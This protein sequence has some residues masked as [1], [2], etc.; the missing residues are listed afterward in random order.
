M[1]YQRPDF[2]PMFVIEDHY[3]GEHSITELGLR[4]EGYE[5]VLGGSYLGR[6]FGNYAIWSLSSPNVIAQ[7]YS[8]IKK[9][10]VD[11]SWQSQL[12]SIGSRG[13][14]LLGKLFRSR[15]HWKLV[16]DISHTVVTRG[17]VGE[18]MLTSTAR[19]SDGQ[20][21]IVYIPSGNSALVAVDMTKITS[22]VSTVHA[23][24][25]NPSSGSTTDLG[26]FANN[27]AHNFICPSSN[28]WI[29]VLDDSAAS[30]PAPGS[31]DL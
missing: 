5:A 18:A 1:E 13:Q 21:I 24:W 19:T 31:R 12:N 7:K 20:T 8:I 23:W 28:D 9:L 29:L 14:M 4:K 3:E 10:F 27:G 2:L 30:L 26:T 17:Y 25:F 16:P 22:S 6:F 11:Y 15:A